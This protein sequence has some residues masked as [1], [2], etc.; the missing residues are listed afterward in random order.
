MK[1]YKSNTKNSKID[2]GSSIRNR[3]NNPIEIAKKSSIIYLEPVKY[4]AGT[5]NDFT[6]ITYTTATSTTTGGTSYISSVTATIQKTGAFTGITTSHKAQLAEREVFYN[7]TS[8]SYEHSDEDDH[9]LGKETIITNFLTIASV[10]ANEIQIRCTDLRYVNYVIEFILRMKDTGIS[11]TEK[12]AMFLYIL[13]LNYSVVRK[14]KSSIIEYF[15]DND[16]SAANKDV[17]FIR[18]DSAAT[19]K[20]IPAQWDY[21]SSSSVSIWQGLVAKAEL[22]NSASAWTEYGVY[23]NIIPTLDEI[24]ENDN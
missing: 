4:K 1:S 8:D 11:T 17:M 3:I 9:W 16:R 13:P 24:F 12:Q 18:D 10:S 7:N 22:V 19:Q 15:Y 6:S 2:K 5:A 14:K 21:D 23:H 20:L